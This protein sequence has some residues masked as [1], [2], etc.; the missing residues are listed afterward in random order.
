MASIVFYDG[1]CDIHTN[2]LVQMHQIRFAYVKYGYLQLEAEVRWQAVH[3]V[4]PKTV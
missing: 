2:V 3:Q 4:D 1:S